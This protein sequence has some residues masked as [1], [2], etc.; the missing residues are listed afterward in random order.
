MSY[1]CAD[2]ERYYDAQRTVHGKC[3]ALSAAYAGLRLR[4]ETARAFA[5]KGFPRRLALME[6]CIGAAMEA[7]PPRITWSPDPFAIL[8]ATISL[9]AFVVNV[10]GCVDNLA[11]AWV[12]E[13]GLSGEDGAPLAASRVGFGPGN[14]AVLKSLTEEFAGYLSE[15]GPWF[16]YLARFRHALEHDAPLYVPA[17]AVPEETLRE[18]GELGER[19]RDAENHRDRDEADRL[20]RER[21]AL[22]SFFPIVE[23]ALGENADK[24]F[25]HFQMMSDFT[26]WPG[27]PPIMRKASSLKAGRMSARG[28]RLSTARRVNVI[29]NSGSVLR[30]GG[31]YLVEARRAQHRN[32]LAPC[33]VTC[34]YGWISNADTPWR[35]QK[36]FT[37]CGVHKAVQRRLVWK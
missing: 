22:V 8:D 23:H 16:A 20:T 18:Y 9:Q 24:G 30:A 11:H 12:L 21:S 10:R 17:S 29:L 1:S 13:K 25:F 31:Q 37:C 28:S 34:C 35:L 6:Q 15:L 33:A 3:E 4:N 27:R 14:A 7:F 26:G 19:I 2:I 32:V 5:R 36:S